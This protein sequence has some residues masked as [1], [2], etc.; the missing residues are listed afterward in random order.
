MIVSH[1]G[2]SDILSNVVVYLFFKLPLHDLRMSFFF[3][4]GYYVQSL[5]RLM[6]EL[7]VNLLTSLAFS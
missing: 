4:K 1:Y 6:H 7:I 2:Y 5:F 3:E